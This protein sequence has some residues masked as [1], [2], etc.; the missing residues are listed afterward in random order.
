MEPEIP[1][2]PPNYTKNKKAWDLRDTPDSKDEMPKI[3]IQSLRQLSERMNKYRE[4]RMVWYNG[5]GVKHQDFSFSEVYEK[6]RPM[7]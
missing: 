4:I 6:N 3:Q 2:C 1:S 7:C 5:K